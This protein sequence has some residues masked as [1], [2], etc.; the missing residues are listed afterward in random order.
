MNPS[1][2]LSPILVKEIFNIVET[3]NE[4]GV[5]ILLVEQ[6]ARMALSISDTGLI[7]ENGRFVMTREIRGVDGRPGCE[8]ILH[9]HPQRG[10]GKR[11]PTVET[12]ETMAIET[13][14]LMFKTTVEKYGDRT[15]M[16]KKGVRSVA[17][18]ILECLL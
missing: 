1:L 3:I 4:Q 7:L 8:R 16:R 18:Y 12:E 9:G 15:A 10:I 11:I 13:A 17:R 14:P 5:T 2:G 6:N